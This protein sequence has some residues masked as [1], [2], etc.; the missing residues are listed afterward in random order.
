VVLLAF[1]LLLCWH[2]VGQWMLVAA[3]LYAIAILLD[4]LRCTRNL[5]VSLLSVVAS[6]IQMLAYGLG[7][8]VRMAK[9]Q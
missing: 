1:A 8:L 6:A 2:P 5:W 4:A 7:F 3:L 9:G